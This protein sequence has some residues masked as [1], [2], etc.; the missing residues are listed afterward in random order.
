ML[1]SAFCVSAPC[2]PT[3]Q[4][5]E[6]SAVSAGLV[7]PTTIETG[8]EVVEMLPPAVVAVAWAVIVC[9]PF[10]RRVVSSGKEYGAL[11]RLRR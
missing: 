7:P 6:G 9:V 5:P 3:C 8:A 1:P 10:E 2:Q 11:V 4:P